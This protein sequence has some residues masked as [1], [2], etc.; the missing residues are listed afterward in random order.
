MEEGSVQ[1]H[2]Y[3]KSKSMNVSS[4]PRTFMSLVTLTT[5][6]VC[7]A[8]V[9]GRRMAPVFWV[10]LLASSAEHSNFCEITEG[11]NTN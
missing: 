6:S 4:Q 2:L 8:L 10:A 1:L 5:S 7:L 3:D 11:E 9:M